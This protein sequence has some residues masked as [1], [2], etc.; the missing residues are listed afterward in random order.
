MTYRNADLGLVLAR[1]IVYLIL[2]RDISSPRIFVV[3]VLGD[4]N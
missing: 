3:H 4:Q 1:H 2:T